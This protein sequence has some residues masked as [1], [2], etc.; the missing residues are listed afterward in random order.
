MRLIDAHEHPQIRPH[1][2]S[3]LYNPRQFLQREIFWLRRELPFRHRDV[4]GVTAASQQAADLFALFAAG[5]A[6]VHDHTCALQADD[7][8]FTLRRRVLAGRLDQVSAVHAGGRDLD[9][10]LALLELR[11][12]GVAKFKGARVFRV[13]ELDSLHGCIC[14]CV[15]GCVHGC[16]HASPE[17]CDRGGG[18][19][20]YGLLETWQSGRMHRS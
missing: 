3:D 12:G 19:Y 4:L 9:Q 11:G 10:H 20:S 5:G 18:V 6:R 8:G 2:T 7:L 14:W 16:V 13:R 15:H 17:Y 1:R